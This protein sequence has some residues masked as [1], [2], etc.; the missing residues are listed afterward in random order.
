MTDLSER[1]TVTVDGRTQGGRFSIEN[2]RL[3]V[4]TDNGDRGEDDLGLLPPS[5]LARQLL[6]EILRKRRER[7]AG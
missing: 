2:G 4:V 5:W 6:R 3:I 7:E 1:I